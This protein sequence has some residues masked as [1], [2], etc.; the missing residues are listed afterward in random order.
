MFNW[1]E[2]V[3]I[4]WPLSEWSSA[5]LAIYSKKQREDDTNIVLLIVAVKN[6]RGWAILMEQTDT[7][8]TNE[9]TDKQT[10]RQTNWLIL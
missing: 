7:Q 8:I 4:Y 3:I 9:Q 2:V 6:I 10:D 1:G 5:L